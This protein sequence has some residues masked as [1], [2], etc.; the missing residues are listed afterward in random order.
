MNMTLLLICLTL[1]M[2]PGTRADADTAL[3]SG[4]QAARDPRLA[5]T[6]FEQATA[7]YDRLWE[8]GDHGPDLAGERAKAHYLTGRPDRAIHAL[9]QGLSEHPHHRDLQRWLQSIRD[10]IPLPQGTPLQLALKA[11]PLPGKLMGLDYTSGM[12]LVLLLSLVASVM[13]IARITWDRGGWLGISAVAM[14]GGTLS[15]LLDDSDCQARKEWTR[16]CY[17]VPPGGCELHT[18]NSTEYPRR[19][20]TRIPTG[21]ELFILHERGGWYQVELPDGSV[22]WVRGELRN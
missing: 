5:R 11:R 18:G 16:P 20:E 13:L 10:Q 17:I 19:F 6:H 14:F 21:V 4:M 3:Q 7:I 9:R 1:E 2:S 12:I 8:S 22:G 15:L